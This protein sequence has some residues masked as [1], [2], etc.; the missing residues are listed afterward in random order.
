[1][2]DSIITKILREKP[3]DYLVLINRAIEYSNY[4]ND[5]EKRALNYIADHSEKYKA[6]V[7]EETFLKEFPYFKSEAL[8]SDTFEYGF[9]EFLKTLKERHLQKIVSSVDAMIINSD[10]ENLE[11]LTK[12]VNTIPSTSHDIPITGV[13]DDYDDYSDNIF[14]G[15]DE[16]TG[17][18]LGLGRYID[19][20]VGHI[21]PSRMISIIAHKKNGKTTLLS[22]LAVKAYVEGKK[23]LICTYEITREGMYE[24]LSP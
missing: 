1:M 6:L 22:N 15:L 10:Y 23:V 20:A 9:D 3:E 11:E 21:I 17:F 14:G 8:L 24:K 13:L 12:M 2:L 16:N 18:Q 19:E 7:S 4:L 5:M